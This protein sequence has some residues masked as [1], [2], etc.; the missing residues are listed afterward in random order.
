[1]FR[2]DIHFFP[3]SLSLVILLLLFFFS[4]EEQNVVVGTYDYYDPESRLNT[5]LN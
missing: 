2:V 1:M 4:L 5:V 3:L